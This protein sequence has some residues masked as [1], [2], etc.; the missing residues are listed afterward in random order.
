MSDTTTKGAPAPDL[1]DEMAAVD[2]QMIGALADRDDLLC[3]D[4]ADRLATLTAQVATLT[5]ALRMARCWG[6]RSRNYDSTISRRLGEWV[7][8]GMSGPLPEVPDFQQDDL[9]EAA[10][11]DATHD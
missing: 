1:P 6:I 3:I 5:E 7:R 9:R 11:K 8:Q 4:A 2:A 10:L